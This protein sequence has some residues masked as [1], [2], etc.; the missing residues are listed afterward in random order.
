MKALALLAG[1]LGLS[2]FGILLAYT[3]AGDVARA[4]ALAG[5]ATVLIVILRIVTIS[6]AGIA[7]HLL[8][9]PAARPPLRV[10]IMLRLIRD[11][12]NQLLPL[13][14]VGGD[15]IG[16]RL[17]TFWRVDGVTASAATIADLAVQAATQIV[18]AIAGVGILMWFHGDSALVRFAAGGVAI[19]ALLIG[20]FFL[21]QARFGQELLS[22]LLRRFGAERFA[23]GLVER[24]WEALRAVY[25]HPGRIVGSAALHLAVWF[26]GTLEV[27]VALHAMGYPVGIAEALVIESLGQAVKGAAFAVPGGLGVQEGGFIALCALFG[28]PAG[29]ALALSLLKRVPDFVIGIPSLI[30]WHVIEARHALRAVPAGV[31][32]AGDGRG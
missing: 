16:A 4:I 29:T 1:I 25:E 32:P 23:A 14:Q 28:V 30:A 19:A 11:G 5:W 21:A 12:T 8:Y 31:A 17:V 24:L 7:W 26:F 15:F 18:F 22:R 9:P 20:G 13:G 3:G 6:G 10:S 27:Y 2:L